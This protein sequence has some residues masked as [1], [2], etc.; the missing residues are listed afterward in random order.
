ML[1]KK[2]MSNAEV[3]LPGKNLEDTVSSK[4]WFLLC[5]GGMQ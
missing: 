3:F 5:Q 1:G 4:Q 2:E